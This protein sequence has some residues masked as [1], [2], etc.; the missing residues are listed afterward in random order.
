MAKTVGKKVFPKILKK[1]QMMH[2]LPALIYV[3][4]LCILI[5]QRYL[6]FWDDLE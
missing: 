6:S 1:S 3:F 2:C 4:T 5:H